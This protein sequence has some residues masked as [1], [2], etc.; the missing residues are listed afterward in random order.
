[1]ILSTSAF[2]GMDVVWWTVF[3]IILIWLFVVPFDIPGQSKRKESQLDILKKRFTSGDITA[4]EFKR[5][6]RQLKDD[7]ENRPSKKK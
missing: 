3:M 2:L 5:E 4:E 7:P 1:M 6:S